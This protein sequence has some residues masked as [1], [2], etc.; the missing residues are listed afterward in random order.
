MLATGVHACNGRERRGEGQEMG[1]ER[2]GEERRGEEG[3]R[4]KRGEARGGKEEGSDSLVVCHLFCL[5]PMG[6]LN[7]QEAR[8]RQSK[9]A[10]QTTLLLAGGCWRL[11]GWWLACG[12]WW[13]LVVAARWWL[14]FGDLRLW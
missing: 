6:G 7:T 4:E 11:A 5:W 3:R 10:N 1:E 12:C 8:A 9:T 13:W 2:R 14:R